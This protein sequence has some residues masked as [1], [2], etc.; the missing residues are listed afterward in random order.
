MR[1]FELAACEL[2]SALLDRSIEL[3]PIF[4]GQ[5]VV[6]REDHLDRG[7]LGQLDGFI[8]NDLSFVD[9]SP[10][11]FHAIKIPCE[12]PRRRG[13]SIR[14]NEVAFVS[15]VGD[16]PSSPRQ[17]LRGAELGRIGA[18]VGYAPPASGYISSGGEDHGACGS[19]TVIAGVA[20]VQDPD[21]SRAVAR[22]W[23]PAPSTVD[24][25]MSSP[26][27]NDVPARPEVSGFAGPSNVTS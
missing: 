12:G 22:T 2:H 14:Y 13:R 24:W 23:T 8:E 5:L 19:N 27:E 18:R 10:Y 20:T 1:V 17:C 25:S 21:D 26:Y 6:L 15:V 9:M 16:V 7:P 4:S 3:G 11:G